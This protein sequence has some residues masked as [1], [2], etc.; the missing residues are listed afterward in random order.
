LF[1]VLILMGSLDST[2][3]SEEGDKEETYSFAEGFAKR[4]TGRF[5]KLTG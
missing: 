4:K 2:A 1:P 3:D 5:Y